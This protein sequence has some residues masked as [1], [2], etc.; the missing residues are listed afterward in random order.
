MMVDN[1]NLSTLISQIPE[2]QKLHHT[3]LAHPEAQQ[4][5]AQQMVQRRQRLEKTQVAKSEGS[6]AESEVDPEGHQENDPG[7]H[8]GNRRKQHHETEFESD[9]GHLIDTKV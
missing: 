6:A 1:L 5:L 2:A 7:Q 9:Q 4:A 3:Q 8:S